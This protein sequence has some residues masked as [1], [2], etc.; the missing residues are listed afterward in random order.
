M[1]WLTFCQ[2]LS[3]HGIQAVLVASTNQQRLDAYLE[4]ERR[5]LRGQSSRLGDRQITRADLAEVRTEIVRLQMLCSRERSK[6][7]R[8]GQADF[9]GRT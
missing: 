4:A 2:N 9:G 8:F 7:G 6:G 3:Q 1:G 5:I